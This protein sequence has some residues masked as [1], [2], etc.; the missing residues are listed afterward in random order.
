MAPI[1][2]LVS[3][4]GKG[5]R[6]I[7]QDAQTVGNGV[8]LAIPPELTHHTFYVRGNGAIG[9]GAVTIETA[10]DANYSGTWAPIVNDLPTPS[11]NPVVV[12]ASAEVIYRFR[13]SFAALRARISTTVTTSTVTVTYVGK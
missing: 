13:G 9:A 1:S 10:S 4:P 2:G 6:V 11:V 12:V 8:A 7:V 3:A 5:E